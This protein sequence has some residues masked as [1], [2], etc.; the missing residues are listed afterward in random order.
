[1]RFSQHANPRATETIAT[2]MP[3]PV[4]LALFA[5]AEVSSCS[6]R[7]LLLSY[8]VVMELGVDLFP[9]GKSGTTTIQ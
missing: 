9:G 4:D 2:V 7:T 5:G 6:S 1:M 3:A 8:D